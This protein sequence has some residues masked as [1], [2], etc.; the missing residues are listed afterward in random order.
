MKQPLIEVKNLKKHFQVGR[1]KV[2]KAVDGVNFTIQHGETLGMVGESGCGKSTVGRTMLR[3]YEPTSGEML[4]N[5]ENMFS[6]SAKELKQKRRDMQMIFQDPYA[7]LNP[8]MTVRD[9]IA[10]PLDIHKLSSSKKARIKRVEELLDL[11][12]LNPD[13]A[14]R[15]P[16]E[17][18]GGQRQRIGIA[19]ALAVNPKFIICDEPISALDVSIQAQVVNLLKELQDQFGLTYLFIA[20]DLSMVK[21]ISDRV[22]VM[23][24]G[25]I[26]ELADSQI[27]Y[28]DP[29]HPYTKALM[30]AIPIPDP[31]VEEHREGIV[32]TGD[33]P[34]PI[35]PPSGCAFRTRCPIA[36]DKCAEVK[37]E[38]QEI[39]PGHWAA[40]H[41]TEK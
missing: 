15:Y 10:E 32:L 23:Y 25:N 33:L 27:L 19:R 30:S 35:N 22:I 31:D 5:G 18:S 36:S 6:L 38:F 4:V 11:V 41:Y 7:S 21:H 37:P 9:I 40:C 17:F 26:V 29:L 8:R 13:H 1:G 24:L 20:H 16:H 2:L 34:S 14:N 3:L 12:G 39:R 28:K